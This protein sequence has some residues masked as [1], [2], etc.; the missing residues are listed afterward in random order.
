MDIP[1]ENSKEFNDGFKYCTEEALKFLRSL[2]LMHKY[3]DLTEKIV[4]LHRDV[5]EAEKTKR[6]SGKASQMILDRIR[7]K[8]FERRKK[9]RE[10]WRPWRK[11]T[12]PSHPS[13]MAFLECSPE[14]P[15]QVD[16]VEDR[17][18]SSSST[19]KESDF[20]EMVEELKATLGG[21]KF[22]CPLCNRNFRD[23]SGL[24]SHLMI[25]SGEKPFQCQ[26]CGKSFTQSGALTVH[27]RTHTGDRPF[28][29][30]QCGKRFVQA[31]QLKVHLRTH[32]GER[33]EVCPLCGKR[34]MQKGHLKVHMQRHRGEKPF[35]CN[36]CGKSF[37]Q[38]AQLRTHLRTHTGEKPFEC[39]QCGKK[40]AQASSLK[41]HLLQHQ[42][43]DVQA[44]LL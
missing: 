15:D 35:A 13:M 6:S 7:R 44:N 19:S 30:D 38:P 36:H 33:M 34:F 39:R 32:N 3:P 2:Q 20:A 27:L 28:S 29:C 26:E 37:L 22:I 18:M 8:I 12:I 5:E 16:F 40:Y 41:H 11:F 24:R 43:P 4:Q 10:I 14:N 25:H 23:K 42:F 21:S 31:G 17:L 9:K 1:K